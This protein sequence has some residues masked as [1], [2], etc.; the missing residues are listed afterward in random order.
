LLTDANPRKKERKTVLSFEAFVSIIMRTFY[1]S[2]NV[3]SS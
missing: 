2:L 3:F 1:F